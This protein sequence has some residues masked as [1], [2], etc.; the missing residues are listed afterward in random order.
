[1]SKIVFVKKDD[2]IEKGFK[3]LEIVSTA[4]TPPGDLMSV[5]SGSLDKNLFKKQKVGDISNMSKREPFIIVDS[6]KRLD[7]VATLMSRHKIHRVAVLDQRGELC[8]VISLS[9]IIECSAQLFGIDNDLTAMG[10][11][12]VEQLSLGLDK[13]VISTSQ[14]KPAI[15]AFKIIARMSVSGIGVTDEQN[16]LVGVISDHDLNLIKSQG[17]YLNLLYQPITEYL[18][19]IK[20]LTNCPRNVVTCKKSDTFKDVV[21]KVAENKIHRIFV[22]N[23]ENKLLGV[24]SLLDILEFIVKSKQTTQD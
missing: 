8:N 23:D 5:L 20:K 7:E 16:R 4:N 9:R 11:K 12:T 19:A 13:E 2:G 3:I 10:S 18:S 21:Q 24:I 15:D 22:V 14:D 17:Q 1:M 6:E